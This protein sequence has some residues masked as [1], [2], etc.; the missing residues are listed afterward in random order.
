MSRACLGK[1][2]T[3][4]YIKRLKTTVIAPVE[5]LDTIIRRHLAQVGRGQR[6]EKLC[7]RLFCFELLGDVKELGRV[8]ARRALDTRLGDVAAVMHPL[9]LGVSHYDGGCSSG[10]GSSSSQTRQP[11]SV[12]WIAAAFENLQDSE[13]ARPLQESVLR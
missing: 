11:S 10:S 5:A 7:L 1:K 13:Q 4:I 6:I 2:I 3:I 12:S 9:P 8:D